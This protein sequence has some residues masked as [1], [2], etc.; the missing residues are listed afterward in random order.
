MKRILSILIAVFVGASA[1][2]VSF[3]NMQEMRMSVFASENSEQFTK[4]ILKK[5]EI[6]QNYALEQNVKNISYVRN[7]SFVTLECHAS[8]MTGQFLEE[9]VLSKEKNPNMDRNLESYMLE[10]EVPLLELTSEELALEM[11]YDEMEIVAVIVQAEAG[12]QSLEGMRLVADVVLNRIDSDKFPDT[13]EEVIFQK[14]QF[15]PVTDGGF[16]R[17]AWNMSENAYKAVEMEWD[18]ETRLNTGILYFNTSWDNGTKP[19][20]VGDHWFSY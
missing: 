7:I 2:I 6:N 17:A 19:F 9:M 5:K 3:G 10:K 13:A 11:M 4:K 16:E 14:G 12:N 20:K 8:M 18:R 1:Q 15:G